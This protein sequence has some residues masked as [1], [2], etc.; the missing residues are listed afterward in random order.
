MVSDGFASDDLSAAHVALVHH[1]L[2]FLQLHF[3]LCHSFVGLFI[4]TFRLPLHLEGCLIQLIHLLLKLFV[5]ALV[6][7][8]FVSLKIII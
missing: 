6:T 5:F 2:G 7:S 4:K 3:F 8:H 1:G